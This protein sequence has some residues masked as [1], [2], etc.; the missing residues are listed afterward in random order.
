M[1]D[2]GLYPHQEKALKE[3]SNG[4][5]LFGGVGSGKSIT[6]VAYYL[7]NEAPRD[8]Y[9]ITT[10][11]KR[12]SLDWDS[13]FVKIGVSVHGGGLHGRLVVDSWN[14][15]TKYADVKDAFFIFDEQR[16]VGSGVWTKVFLK[17]A[18]A[19]H[20]ILLSGTPGDTWLDY[21]PVFVANGWYKNRTDF[22]RQH[23]VYS[24]YSKFPKV[25]HYVDTGRLLRHRR[26][27]L[28]HM[29]YQRHT[30][31]LETVVEVS[32]DKDLEEQIWKKRWNVYDDRP[33][34]DVGELCRVARKAVNS[35]ASRI[36]ALKEILET[37]PRVIVFYNF[38]YELEILREGLTENLSY[39]QNSLESLSLNP[40][41]TNTQHLV[42][43]QKKR[44]S[45]LMDELRSMSCVA[46][47]AESRSGTAKI[48]CTDMTESSSL[49]KSGIP[50]KNRQTRYDEDL[51]YRSQYDS[52]TSSHQ[53]D[54][55]TSTDQMSHR[56]VLLLE[57]E[58]KQSE[59]KHKG[60]QTQTLL[61][62]ISGFEECNAEASPLGLEIF[63]MDLPNG[64]TGARNTQPS[65]CTQSASSVSIAEWN[66]H[67]HED[68][69]DSERWVY[70]VQYNAGAEGWNCTSTD[71]V[72]FYSLNYSYKINEQCKGRIDRM[73]T[74]FTD[75]K[76][77]Y[78]KSQSKID[79]MIWKSVSHKEDFQPKM[80]FL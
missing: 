40:Q 15:I 14:N 22:K 59:K 77:F 21:I 48:T 63:P 75:L 17:L 11:K 37:S 49:Q 46:E 55:K 31:R 69:P 10:A 76:Y 25:D 51:G 4:K 47:N 1:V 39:P 68:I 60:G 12:D 42:Y 23:V 26:D 33:L 50:L 58:S 16:L 36:T 80:A 18:K 19:N 74:L 38:D 24:H 62:N 35:D 13:E 67:K 27:V 70:L 57:N 7:S 8:V 52:L 41:S 71:T 73:N 44:S 78:L 65:Q 34:K 20:W 53:S 32:Y 66:G 5:V 64:S 72:V 29:P 30:K 3:L 6:A 9:V 43:Q 45:S 28:V 61:K 56:S 79:N 2:L 54:V